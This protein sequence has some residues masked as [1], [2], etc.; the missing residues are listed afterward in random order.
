MAAVSYTTRL[1][2]TEV[3]TTA[4][5]PVSTAGARGAR[6]TNLNDYRHAPIDP[7]NQ[8]NAIVQELLTNGPV[9]LWETT[10]EDRDVQVEDTL[11]HKGQAYTVEAMARYDGPTFARVEGAFRYLV[12]RKAKR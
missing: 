1:N 4:S 2:F 8:Q 10:G 3:S 5:P 11:T 12:L 6:V 7:A 9:E